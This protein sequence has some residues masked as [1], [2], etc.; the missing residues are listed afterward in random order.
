[1]KK[2][3]PAALIAALALT[4]GAG[5]LF[6]NYFEK[7]PANGESGEITPGAAE[8]GGAYRPLA[9]KPVSETGRAS[10]ENGGVF[11]LEANV[12][13]G[14]IG[15]KKAYF[16][17][18]NSQI[19]GPVLSV[20]QGSSVTIN[21]K[22]NLDQPTTVHWHG[23]RLKN[24]N[25]GVP[26]VTQSEVKP[27]ESFR[28][29]LE[30]PDEGVYWYH[31]HVREE[32]QQE[33]GLYGAILVKP[34]SAGYFNKVS[35]EEVL[36]LDDMLLKD[37]EPY[38]FPEKV[39]DF[40]IMGRYGNQMLVNGRT[41]YS[42]SVKAG[43]VV[44]F[45][46]L[47]AANVRPFKFSIEGARLKV[48]GGDSGK[49][50]REF[51]ADDVTIAPSERYIVEA[52]FDKPGKYRV[53]NRNPVK[54]WSL[55]EITVTAGE[56]LEKI[57]FEPPKANPDIAAGIDG[58]REYFEKPADFEYTLTIDI[59][60][61]MPM[62]MMMEHG[63]DGIEWEDS[64][65]GMNRVSTSDRLKWIIREDK[66]GR[67]NAD[68]KAQIQTGKIFKVRI[69]NDGDSLHPMQHPIHLHGARFLVLKADG[70]EN[71]NLVWKDSVLAPIGKSVE[72]LTYFPNP[73]EWMLH[74]HIAEHLSSGMM[75]SIKA[76]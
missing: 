59:P 58:Y 14:S 25:D 37:G 46:L 47:N 9:F 52:R 30:F 49:F 17:G 13:E 54:E 60:G 6:L 11:A 2:I 36:F 22:N 33:R 29:E 76:V 48:V 65:F 55:G 67:E 69:R 45:Y 39:T 5:A 21:F 10:I 43:E 40:A 31:P 63:E 51:L 44:R 16:Y 26:G 23:L 7:A 56:P 42:L 53:L 4:L 34:K 73:G 1:M 3:P 71:D 50:E 15:N 72:L 28:Y 20:D 68:I 24:A 74:C 27:G 70:R 18:Y 66:T 41:S 38:P 12:I 62:G 75:T 35:R 61:A 19:P 57:I 32:L 64:M 8:A